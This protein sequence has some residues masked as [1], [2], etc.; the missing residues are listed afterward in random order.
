MTILSSPNYA[1][2][3]KNPISDSFAS[4]CDEANFA[5]GEVVE[6]GDRDE[7]TIFDQERFELL[8]GDDDDDFDDDDVVDPG[9]TYDLPLF[10]EC[11]QD[12]QQSRTSPQATDRIDRA[13]NRARRMRGLKVSLTGSLLVSA[14]LS[15][16]S[17]IAS[18]PLASY[19]QNQGASRFT[20]RAVAVFP[21]QPNKPDQ[22]LTYDTPYLAASMGITEVASIAFPVGNE[23]SEG[24]NRPDFLKFH[25]LEIDLRQAL[26][27]LITTP[28]RSVVTRLVENAF[29]ESA[30]RLI[31][32]VSIVTIDLLINPV[33]SAI[34]TVGFLQSSW[35][36]PILKR[37]EID[38]PTSILQTTVWDGAGGQKVFEIGDRLTQ[39][40]QYVIYNFG[41]VGTGSNPSIE[42][43][44][45]LDAL[46]FIG[47]RFTAD[48]LQLNQCEK[49]LVITF[50]GNEFVKV[51]L[52]DRQRED[53]DNLGLKTVEGIDPSFGVGNIL[54]NND[55]VIRDT[56]DVFNAVLPNPNSIIYPFN[57][58]TNTFFNDQNNL[59]Q[60]FN[61][62]N[63]TIHGLGGNDVIFGLSGDDI[64]FGD[65][66]NDI[67]FG[68]AGNNI[69]T[70]GS[71][72]DIFALSSDGFSRVTDFKVGEGDRIGLTGGLTID[73]LSI[74]TE[75][76]VNGSTT[77]I[78]D[79]FTRQRLIELPG[80]TSMALTHDLFVPISSQINSYIHH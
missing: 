48:K 45:G 50:T 20:D 73:R 1:S 72:A 38:R 12:G 39:P 61:H 27:L 55:R 79:R 49:D 42:V 37:E 11:S 32:K 76:T 44:K 33:H 36:N 35:V 13:P 40:Q 47:D 70:G 28:L 56:I 53:F 57:P 51:I 30:D 31:P 6:D 43:R 3:G 19:W 2:H 69:L 67:L 18:T 23:P 26:G 8:L 59:I 74:E 14:S 65:D 78:S 62:S 68:N 7:W 4:G 10:T 34:Q 64:I 41:L 52:K 29:V 58:N 25:P 54:F 75:V 66:G 22:N 9:D 71:G 46:K 16:P 63:D 60:G 80:V 17:S 15:R 5:V 21:P 24:L 77:W